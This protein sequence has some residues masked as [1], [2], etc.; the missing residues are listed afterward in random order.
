MFPPLSKGTP[1]GAWV[2]TPWQRGTRDPSGTPLLHSCRPTSYRGNSATTSLGL[3]TYGTRMRSSYT[4]RV[5]YAYLSPRVVTAHTPR[6]SLTPSRN[7]V[8]DSNRIIRRP[9]VGTGLVSLRNA[10]T[11]PLA[12][13]IRYD[14]DCPRLRS[15]A[16][17][18]FR[19]PRT[20]A[21][22]VSFPPP[23]GAAYLGHTHTRLDVPYPLVSGLSPSGLPPPLSGVLLSRD[24]AGPQLGT[25]IWPSDRYPAP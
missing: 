20:M 21:S 11:K 17:M 1:I 24:S 13:L 18:P 5:L 15:P 6:G 19:P 2:C 22:D 4:A 14:S 3:G 7:Y 16:R 8:P 25:D 10:E 9:A 23:T 12:Y